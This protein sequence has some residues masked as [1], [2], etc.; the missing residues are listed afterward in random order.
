[1]PIEF[2]QYLHTPRILIQKIR[3]C[4]TSG[5]DNTEI[6]NRN[7]HWNYNIMPWIGVYHGEMDVI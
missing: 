3:F 2:I 5:C 4:Y 6:S 1:M 7:K